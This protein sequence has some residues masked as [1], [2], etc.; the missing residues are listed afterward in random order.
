[1]VVEGRPRSDSFEGVCLGCFLIASYTKKEK[2]MPIFSLRSQIL[3]ACQ[4]KTLLNEAATSE[5]MEMKQEVPSL[6]S[7]ALKD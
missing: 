3:L 5:R 1:M 6:L 4:L 2:N 7:M